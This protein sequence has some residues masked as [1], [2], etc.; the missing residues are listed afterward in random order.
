MDNLVG[1]IG[2]LATS[3]RDLNLFCK[4]MLE[5][6]AWNVEHQNLYME[7]KTNLAEHGEGLPKKLIIGFL[8]DDG[9]VTPHPPL[10]R[11]MEDTKRALLA[12]GH[13]VVDYPLL[14]HQAAW[15]LI[16][17]LSLLFPDP[18]A[19]PLF[20]SRRSPFSE[21]TGAEVKRLKP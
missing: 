9:V 7:W 19:L 20:R 10:R 11:A 1:C 12:A 14:D 8:P 5:Y 17:S 3:A 4:V 16:V 13:E 15:D 21:R 2:P 6:Q 18:A